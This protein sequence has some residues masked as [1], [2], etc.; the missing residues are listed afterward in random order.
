VRAAAAEALGASGAEGPSA[1]AGPALLRSL[2]SDADPAVRAAAAEALGT[3]RIEEAVPSLRA[4]AR[5][6]AATSRSALFALARIRSGAALEALR[7][8]R[9]EA[10]APDAEAARERRDLVDF[11]LSED[12]LRQEEALRRLRDG[13]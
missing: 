5:G 11:L 6:E 3:L 10:G 9:D 2:Q 7:A 12:F 13:R 4:A 1:G 8:V